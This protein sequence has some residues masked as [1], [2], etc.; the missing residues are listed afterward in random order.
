MLRQLVGKKIVAVVLDAETECFKVFV[1]GLTLAFSI[2]ADDITPLTSPL[3]MAATLVKQ[4]EPDMVSYA[5]LKEALNGSK[6]VAAPAVG[7]APPAAG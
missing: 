4:A 2:P 6:P 5:A 1:E 7:E 3:E